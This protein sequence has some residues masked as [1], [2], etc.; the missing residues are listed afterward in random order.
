MVLRWP[1]FW[2]HTCLHTK[3]R[4]RAKNITRLNY[5]FGYTNLP[6]FITA[7]QRKRNKSPLRWSAIVKLDQ[8]WFWASINQRRCQK[9]S[10]CSRCATARGSWKIVEDLCSFPY[11]SAID[12][13]VIQSWGSCVR[14]TL[15]FTQMK[16]KKQWSY[17]SRQPVNHKIAR[18]S[19]RGFE[20]RTWNMLR[21][22]P[23]KWHRRTYIQGHDNHRHVS[24]LPWREQFFGYFKLSNGNNPRT[25]MFIT[26]QWRFRHVVHTEC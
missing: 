15:T 18:G 22:L 24:V 8:W 23:Y 17:S 12:L 6:A 25:I 9:Y 7:Q 26:W 4:C 20:H 10:A 19:N 5:D 16:K 2:M 14:K 3:P 11:L 13:S 21:I 1:T